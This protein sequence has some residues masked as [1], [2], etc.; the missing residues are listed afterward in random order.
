MTTW[1][2]SSTFY[3][4]WLPGDPRGSVTNVRERRIPDPRSLVRHE[5]DRPGEEYEPVIPELQRAADGQLKGPPISLNLSQAEQLLDQFL[6]TA[7]HRGW[8]PHAVSIMFNHVHLV[9]EAPTQFGKK[10]L[11]RDFKSY[12]SR[13]LTR[14]AGRPRRRPGG[15]RVDPAGQFGTG[16][17]LFTMSVI[18]N[19]DR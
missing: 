4:Q 6:E 8:V 17:P 16:P 12:G 9:V 15:P 14:V 2:V 10:E 5:H 13:R 19:R 7:H 11:L 1:L 18:G 3:G